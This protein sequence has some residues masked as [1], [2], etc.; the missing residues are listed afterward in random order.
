MDTK[1]LVTQGLERLAKQYRGKPRFEALLSGILA[2][3]QLVED[4]LQ[5]L[6]AILDVDTATGANLRLIGRLVGVADILPNGVQLTD[7]DE[8]R[9]LV[10]LKISRDM[11]LYPSHAAVRDAVVAV[12]DPDET[13][14]DVDLRNLGGMLAWVI[15][16][17]VPTE[18]ERG[19]LMLDEAIIPRGATVKMIKQYI[20]DG[21]FCFS[22]LTDP[23]EPLLSGGHGFNTL[24]GT[25]GSWS[26]LF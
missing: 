4:M 16:Q 7:D 24:G 5:D 14:I 22:T 8:F 2:D 10:R 17:K 13:G 26:G 20:P 18:K 3:G 1:N 23:G 12:V 19:I 11:C 15:I 9:A 6:A 25:L 21:A